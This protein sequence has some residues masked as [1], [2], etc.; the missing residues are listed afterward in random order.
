MYGFSQD[1][2]N[3]CRA[4]I[5]IKFHCKKTTDFC[6]AFVPQTEHHLNS[7]PEDTRALAYIWDLSSK[8]LTDKN[9]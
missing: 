1:A 7:T 8:A 5:Y 9:P 4:Y 2:A 6:I 3:L